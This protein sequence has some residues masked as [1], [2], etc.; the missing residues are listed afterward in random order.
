MGC[1]SVSN[2]NKLNNSEQN[3]QYLNKIEAFDLE[4]QG[5][6]LNPSLRAILMVLEKAKVNCQHIEVK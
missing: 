4:V 3:T 6:F 2:Q 1:I 5:N